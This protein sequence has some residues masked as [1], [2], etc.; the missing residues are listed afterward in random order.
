MRRLAGGEVSG[1]GCAEA[2]GADDPTGGA[3][4]DA[5]DE[6]ETRTR[7]QPAVPAW[8]LTLGWR[9]ARAMR[10]AGAVGRPCR[11]SPLP[12]P[13]EPRSRRPPLRG[14]RRKS[15]RKRAER[16]GA[17]PLRASRSSS[18]GSVPR[19]PR[20]CPQRRGSRLRRPPPRRHRATGARGP[21]PRWG[22]DTWGGPPS[23]ARC[24]RRA[25]L[26]RAPSRRGSRSLPQ[27]PRVGA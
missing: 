23:A 26:R 1:G 10:P 19:P 11:D 5:L 2:A 15:I 4:D 7:S 20:P 9:R 14:Y 25:W 6:D 17:Q 12:G 24:P 13:E 21:G 16:P 22:R 8:R 18:G 27:Q 3:A